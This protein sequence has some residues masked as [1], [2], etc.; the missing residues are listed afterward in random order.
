MFSKRLYINQV[1]KSPLYSIQLDESIDIAGLTQLS[2]FIRYINKVTISEDFLFCQALKLH[3]KGE[4]IF[5]CL[6]SFFL[7]YQFHGIIVLELAQ[8][9]VPASNREQLANPR[10]GTKCLMDPLFSPQSGPCSNKISPELHE[11]LNFVVKCVNLIKATPLN[12]RLFSSLCADMDVDHK[13]LLLHTEVRWLLWGRVLKRFFELREQIAFFLRHQNFGV[14]AEKFRQ[15]EFIAKTAY[16]A[17]IFDSLNS[18]NLSM[19][20]ANFTSDVPIP[21]FKPIS[22]LL[23]IP[24]FRADT[25]TDT[26]DTTDTFLSIEHHQ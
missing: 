17:D 14:L 1:K 15:E 10:K 16:L 13:A 3:T 23:P 7:D 26:A 21:H 5:Q 6:N 12:Q 2:V 8:Q 20:G 19:Q 9:H 11:K 22:I 25:N 18:L 24:A 4:N